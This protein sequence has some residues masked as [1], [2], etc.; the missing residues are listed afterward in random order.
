MMCA[1]VFDSGC[2]GLFLHAL[3]VVGGGVEA[4]RSLYLAA[5]A[6]IDGGVECSR[7]SLLNGASEQMSLQLAYFA[8]PWGFNLE[9]GTL[10]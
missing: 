8:H 2:P 7:V 6:V 10:R 9:Q 4:S 3:G 1:A 5:W